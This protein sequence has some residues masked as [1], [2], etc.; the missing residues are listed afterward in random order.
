MKVRSTFTISLLL[1]FL[2]NTENNMKVKAL[3]AMLFKTFLP[4]VHK[5]D[6]VY[7]HA[8]CHDR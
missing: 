4:G 3:V 7:R 5:S 8:V 2:L 6:S 1:L